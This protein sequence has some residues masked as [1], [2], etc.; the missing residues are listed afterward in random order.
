MV[1][2]QSNRCL[3][4]NNTILN[5]TDAQLWDCHG[6]ENQ[7][8]NNT[9]RKRLVV[10]GNKCLD[11]YNRGTTDGARVVIRDCNDQTNQQ[12]N[13]NSEPWILMAVATPR[14][15][16]GDG[17]RDP[18]GNGPRGPESRAGNGSHAPGSYGRATAIGQRAG[19]RR[20]GPHG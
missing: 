1:G 12:G 7:S 4:I 19:S 18:A 11:A 10:Y 14:F 17:L 3:G 20:R 8:W 5:G 2:Q 13:V 15:R 9:S 16:G 6:G